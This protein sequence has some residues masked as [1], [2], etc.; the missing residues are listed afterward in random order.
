TSTPTSTSTST[1]TRTNTPTSTATATFT[2]TAT[3]P[4]GG[5]CD[6]V[7]VFATCT[8]YQTGAKVIYNN[9]LYHSIAPIASNRD[10]PPTS[11]YNPGNDNFWVSDG[12]C[13]APTATPTPTA[14][15]CAG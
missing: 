13:T 7:P 1:A 5:N 15:S 11:P 2:P 14:I 3:L 8:S 6:G 9:T 10:C 12:A 4:G